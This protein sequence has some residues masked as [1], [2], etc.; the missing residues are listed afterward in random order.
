MKRPP[1]SWPLAEA[2]Y[3]ASAAEAEREAARAATAAARAKA[4]ALVAQ[5]AEAGKTLEETRRRWLQSDRPMQ[6]PR[7]GSKR[8]GRSWRQLRASRTNCISDSRRSWSAREQIAVADSDLQA[9]RYR[10]IVRIV[11]LLAAHFDKSMHFNGGRMVCA[12]SPVTG[13]TGRHATRG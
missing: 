3:Q 2:R 9:P 12:H 8:A 5:L 6:P 1:P 7:H 10:V 11:R 4:E 13:L